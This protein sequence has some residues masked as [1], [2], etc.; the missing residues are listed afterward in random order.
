MLS[1][2]IVIVFVWY[3]STL[4]PIIEPLNIDVQ[5]EGT[6][7]LTDRWRC[8]GNVSVE[9]KANV[10]ITTKRILFN[11]LN[12]TY[13]DGTAEILGI[14]GEYNVST[15]IDSGEKRQMEFTSTE[16]GFDKEPKTLWIALNVSIAEL[17]EPILK[18]LKIGI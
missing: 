1:V 5:A 14:S 17:K 9:N 8:Y 3:L 16:Y 2:L 11:A 18:T 12:V 7:R 6:F 13:V 15:T 10:G 4:S